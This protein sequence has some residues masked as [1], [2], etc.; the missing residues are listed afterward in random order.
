VV[1][2]SKTL[3]GGYLFVY[4]FSKDQILCNCKVYL[5]FLYEITTNSIRRRALN[6]PTMGQISTAGIPISATAHRTKA[7]HSLFNYL[8][9]QKPVESNLAA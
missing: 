8:C 6:P 3:S 9:A 4:L 7:F 2:L 5:Q 1:V